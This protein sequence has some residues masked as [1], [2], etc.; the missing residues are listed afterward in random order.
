MHRGTE[1]AAIV[2]SPIP[3]LAKTTCVTLPEVNRPARLGA[4]GNRAT[5]RGVCKDFNGM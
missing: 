5:P 3:R 4:D 1:R 2:T